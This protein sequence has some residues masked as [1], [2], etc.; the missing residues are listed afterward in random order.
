MGVEMNADGYDVE[1]SG[2]VPVIV[3]PSADLSGR[4]FL[5]PEYVIDAA[6][7]RAF[8]L[9]TWLD[10]AYPGLDEYPDAFP[11]ETVPG[12]MTLSLIDSIGAMTRRYEPIAWHVLNYG[13]D[14]VRFVRPVAVND[15]V[16]VSFT[17]AAAEPADGGSVRITEDVELR[18]GNEVAMAAR[19]ILLAVPRS[20]RSEVV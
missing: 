11:D 18:R 16:R 12:F 19:L 20:P 3:V 9:G 14:R 7:L 4:R 8:E 10:R 2:A 13:L 6:S 5:S 15:V 17:V 1:S